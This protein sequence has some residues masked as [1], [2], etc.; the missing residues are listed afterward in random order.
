MFGA[1]A[2]PYPPVYGLPCGGV[3]EEARPERPD[4]RHSRAPGGPFMQYPVCENFR[5]R[6]KAEVQ[7]RRK[8]LPRT[9]VNKGKKKEGRGVIGL[10]PPSSCLGGGYPLFPSSSSLRPL[11]GC[12]WFRPP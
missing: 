9:P 8:T 5:E 11:G 1:S 10:G 12:P 2:S 4:R 7:L 3:H 6:R